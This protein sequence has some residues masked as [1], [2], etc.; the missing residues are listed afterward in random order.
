MRSGLAQEQRH[1]DAVLRV[2]YENLLAD[3]TGEL[4]RLQQWC[5]LEP[6]PAVTDYARKR[7]YDNPDKRDWPRL[8]PDIDALFR[9]TMQ[10]LGY[11]TP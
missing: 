11:K 4:E 5:E 3:P 2:A 7:L 10:Q 9:E 8:H 6:D 1:P